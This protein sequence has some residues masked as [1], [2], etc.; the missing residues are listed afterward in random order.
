[1]PR[2][3]RLLANQPSCHLADEVAAILCDLHAPGTVTALP[4][5]GSENILMFRPAPGVRL[6]RVY[7][8]ASDI[9]GEL[10]AAYVRI[11]QL[12]AAAELRIRLLHEVQCNG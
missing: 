3:Y 4:E 5:N 2:H 7:L 8:L 11:E 6:R 10:G 1:M 9:A 12:G